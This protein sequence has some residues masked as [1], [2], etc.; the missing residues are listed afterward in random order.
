MP[1]QT[2]IPQ[3]LTGEVQKVQISE[4]LGQKE[5]LQIWWEMAIEGAFQE[6]HS[7]EVPSQVEDFQMWRVQSL[8]GEVHALEGLGPKELLWRIQGPTEKAP[9]V[10]ILEDQVV[11]IGG[12]TLR[13]QSLTV[14]NQEVQGSGN[15]VLEGEV[16]VWRVQDLIGKDQ[17]DQTLE[18]QPLDR[19]VQILKV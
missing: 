6:V 19:K 17:V 11:K 5:D 16:Q 1:V 8:I 15:L 7:S 9:E 13:S 3:C 2:W 12:Q 10:Q 14:K 4:D 18:A